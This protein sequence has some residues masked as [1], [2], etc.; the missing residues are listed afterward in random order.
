MINP[1]TGQDVVVNTPPDSPIPTRPDPQTA[2][3]PQQQTQGV[4][5]PTQTPPQLTPQQQEAVHSHGLGSAFKAIT[6]SLKGSTT[7]YQQTPNGPVPV[8][9][10]NKPGDFFRNILAGAIVGAGAGADSPQNGWS[11]AG[12][13][14]AA[15]QQAGQQRQQQAQ[16]DAQLQFQNQQ[17]AQK[18]QQE[19]NAALT[20]DQV[21]KA[22]IGLFNLQQI[23]ELHAIQAGDYT[24]HKQLV[25]D[26]KPIV[27]AYDA[28][29]FQP[30]KKIS[31]SEHDQL[32]P[33]DKTKYQWIPTGV[34]SFVDKDGR[35]NYQT[36]WSGY[37]MGKNVTI[38][39]ST[40][41]DWKKSGVLSRNPDLVKVLKPDA[42]GNYQMPAAGFFKYQNQ[43]QDLKTKART[44]EQ[45]DFQT[46]K[47]TA[48]LQH[49][50]AQTAQEHAS[51]AASGSETALRSY[52]LKQQ[53]LVTDAQTTLTKA[54]GDWTKLSPEQKVA[55]QPQIQ[56]DI[57]GYRGELADPLLKEQL[58]STDPAVAKVAQDRAAALH[59]QLDEARAH[60]IYV[61]APKPTVAYTGPDGTLYNLPADKVQEFLVTHPGSV[62]VGGSTNGNP[63][64]KVVVQRPDGSTTITTR[65]EHDA[66]VKS[67]PPGMS[68][69][70]IG[71]VVG[72]APPPKTPEEELSGINLTK[73]NSY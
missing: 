6:N 59:Q 18:Q 66:A 46:K 9:V 31:E 14:A 32:S 49:L 40:M 37:D 2:M 55:M 21:Q 57:D 16:K 63:N 3:I 24:A 44:D 8:Q 22:H 71:K 7:Q 45:N 38:P 70:Q 39:P 69:A 47:D 48:E 11:A 5:Q 25:D 60:S 56:K 34:N 54:G 42:E 26:K 29:G 68:S 53:K 27:D 43:S 65:E 4:Q 62:P 58:Q 33:E 50:A 51:A 23:G 41:A 72:P 73:G 28:S 13:G 19:A 30:A 15:A 61:A 17:A 10:P 67:P 36:E 52:E 12:K 64:E 35:V 1:L 20:E